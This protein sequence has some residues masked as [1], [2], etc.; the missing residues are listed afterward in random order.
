MQHVLVAL[1]VT[2]ALGAVAVAAMARELHR[3]DAA[4]NGLAQAAHTLGVGALWLLLA[5]SLGVA[6]FLPGKDVSAF[7]L[8]P[9]IVYGSLAAAFG[10]GVAG[11][12]GSLPWLHRA[13][14]RGPWRAATIAA[15]VVAPLG[16]AASVAWLG[17]AL[18]LTDSAALVGVVLGAAAS[19]VPFAAHMLAPARRPRDDMH[20]VHDVAYPALLF[21]GEADVHVVRD[22]TSLVA[23]AAQ[24]ARASARSV[25]VDSAGGSYV[26]PDTSQPTW[27]LARQA[28]HVGFDEVLARIARI[29]RLAEDPAKDV[30]LRRLVAMQRSVS[31]LSFV[32]PR[33]GAP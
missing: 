11:H 15:G 7:G 1:L 3:S 8:R 9:W 23:L 33:P 18:P 10:L 32:L 16:L 21:Q 4:G 6:L 22:A 14:V 31:A 26:W 27:R 19:L 17:A 2:A 20:A 5:A 29:P 12:V 25:L 30:E 28:E 13:Q 24:D